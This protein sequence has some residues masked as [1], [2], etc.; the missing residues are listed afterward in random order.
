MRPG[1][2]LGAQASS[3]SPCLPKL[4]DP[5]LLDPS[6]SSP[7]FSALGFPPSQAEGGEKACI[8]H[9]RPPSKQALCQ[10]ASLEGIFPLSAL[11]LS[12]PSLLREQRKK[13][14][15]C[16]SPHRIC[17]RASCL[18]VWGQSH[19]LEWN[20]PPPASS[21]DLATPKLQSLTVQGFLRSVQRSPE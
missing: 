16:P 13:L 10:G 20:K 6:P 4:T 15:P 19:G 8:H 17:S 21:P 2:L 5:S 11:P 9:T 18:A 12:L 7:P 14:F 1:W 3:A